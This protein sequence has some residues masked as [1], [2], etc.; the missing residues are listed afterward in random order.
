MLN[1]PPADHNVIPVAPAVVVVPHV[2]AGSYSDAKL[3]RARLQ[4]VLSGLTPASET[5]ELLVESARQHA[6][7]LMLRGP[8]GRYFATWE[9][10]CCAPLPYGLGVPAEAIAAEAIAAVIA[11]RT[12]PRARARAVLE[13]PL[14]LQTRSAPQKGR[15]ACAGA[16][17]GVHLAAPQARPPRPPGAGG[18]RRAD[19]SR[20]RPSWPATA[21]HW[22]ACWWSLRASPG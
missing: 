1:T 17:D 14:L 19:L 4:Q 18:L 20:R 22:R 11:E 16:G 3:L 6:I 10:F 12:D 7:H 2:R 5:L 15:T 9:A 13:G 8:D 21:R